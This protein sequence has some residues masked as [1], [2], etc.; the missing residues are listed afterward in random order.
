MKRI[1]TITSF[2]FAM[3]LTAQEMVV[4]YPYNPD[5]ENDG[6][7]GVE[8]LMQLLSTF[9]VG[10]EANEITINEVALTEWLLTI[11]QTLA[12]QQSLIDSLL[13]VQLD[14]A[15]APHVIEFVAGSTIQPTGFIEEITITVDSAQMVPDVWSAFSITPE[16]E[17]IYGDSLNFTELVAL[18]STMSSVDGLFNGAFLNIDI[19]HLTSSRVLFQFDSVYNPSLL[20]AILDELHQETG[21]DFNIFMWF[22]VPRI[23]IYDGESFLFEK[24]M[25]TIDFEYSTYS[26][27]FEY[28]YFPYENI[29]FRKLQPGVWIPEY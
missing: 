8:D 26:G 15:P 23:H 1:L 17:I 19:S 10:F 20:E 2:L 29:A 18:M 5:F 4:D 16:G 12:T 21:L 7:I 22:F 25:P 27:L 14:E 13:S 28:L 3:N 11:S 24:S 6:N 9:G